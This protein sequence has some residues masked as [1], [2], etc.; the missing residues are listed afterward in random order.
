MN[1]QSMADIKAD[2]ARRIA[3]I[4]WRGGPA[5]VAHEV[6]AIR[7]VAQRHRLL[8]AVT[9]AHLLGAALARGE[10][11]LLVHGWLAILAE[12]VASER[13]DAGACDS[14]AAACAVRFAA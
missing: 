14:F 9:V 5:R 13:Q 10:R 12:A 6:D 1:D 8:P 7:L 4:D 11:G 3:R 2:L